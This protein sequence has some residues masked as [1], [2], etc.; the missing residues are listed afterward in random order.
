[1]ATDTMKVQIWKPRIIKRRSLKLTYPDIIA[2]DTEIIMSELGIAMQ[3]RESRKI[4]VESIIST[5]VEER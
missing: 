5:V 4:Q 2:R 3:D 1:M